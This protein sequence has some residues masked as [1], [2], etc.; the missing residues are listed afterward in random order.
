MRFNPKAFYIIFARF[1]VAF[2]IMTANFFVY[3]PFVKDKVVKIIDA[4]RLKGA[5][6]IVFV[7]RFIAIE[8]RQLILGA[9]CVRRAIL[10]YTFISGNTN[11]LI[12]FSYAHSDLSVAT[13]LIRAQPLY[14]VLSP[15]SLK[16]FRIITARVTLT[17]LS[18]R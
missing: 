10:C 7:I 1:P 16:A 6:T 8:G 3:A 4:I 14:A 18:E 11:F 2:Q 12:N 15:I 9:F 5:E 13:I 17:L